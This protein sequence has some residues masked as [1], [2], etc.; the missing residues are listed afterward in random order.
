MLRK[1]RFFWYAIHTHY[2][3]GKGCSSPLFAFKWRVWLPGWSAAALI[4]ARKY[5]GNHSHIW[6]GWWH[7]AAREDIVPSFWPN[8]Y[9]RMDNTSLWLVK[10][11]KFVRVSL[12]TVRKKLRACCPCPRLTG[13]R[14]WKGTFN[15][16][17]VRAKVKC[18]AMEGVR[19]WQGPY[20]TG[21]T[22]FHMR[23]CLYLKSFSHQWRCTKNWNFVFIFGYLQPFCSLLCIRLSWV[24]N[25]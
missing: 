15:A 7:L 23:A 8:I 14:S 22:V 2:W 17:S 24:I 3:L 12:Y 4:I 20:I 11:S 21:F 5:G 9:G 6:P 25:K 16:K 19:R 10:S 18:P 1:M 13:V